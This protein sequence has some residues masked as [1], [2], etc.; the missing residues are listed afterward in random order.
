MF[1]S[2]LPNYCKDILYMYLGNT[3]YF[4]KEKWVFYDEKS[5]V[6]YIVS[7]GETII[8]VLYGALA[9]QIGLNALR[10]RSFSK[11]VTGNCS[12]FVLIAMRHRV[13]IQRFPLKYQVIFNEI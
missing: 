5:R 2:F 10:Y 12:L 1:Q 6:D 3:F 13:W 8:K 7:S 11:C 9:E 4:M